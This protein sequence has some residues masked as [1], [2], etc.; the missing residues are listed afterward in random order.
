M[1]DLNLPT[2]EGIADMLFNSPANNPP[3]TKEE[4]LISLT[5]N[6]PSITDLFL[7]EATLQHINWKDNHGQQTTHSQ[8]PPSQSGAPD[9]G[10]DGEPGQ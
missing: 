3:K 1:P 10:S 7:L 2:H 5:K 9:S 4:I 8:Y 6:Y